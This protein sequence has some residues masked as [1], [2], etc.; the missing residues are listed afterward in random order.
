MRILGISL[1]HSAAAVLIE[2]GKILAA[3]EEEK[4]IRV[5]GFSGFPLA[6]IDYIL[7]KYDLDISDLDEIAIGC[8]DIVEFVYTYRGLNKFFQ[9]NSMLENI[10]GYV[11]Y[12]LK[13]IFPYKYKVESLMKQH[14]F[15]CMRNI[16]FPK[17][18]IKFID[19]HLAHA[20]SSYYTSPWDMNTIVFTNDG[21]G[22]GHSGGVFC[23]EDNQLVSYDY[24]DQKNSVGQL[25][26][27]IT[28]YLGYTVNRHEGKITGL[29]AHGDYKDTYTIFNEI[30]S[31]T[32][33]VLKNKFYENTSFIKDPINFYRKV[34]TKNF[35]VTKYVR[36]L[37][38]KLMN[39]AIVYQL[40]LNYFKSKLS[41]K[42]PQDIAAGVQKFTE[43]ALTAYLLSKIDSQKRYNL[44]LAG[45][46][47]ANV[48]INQ[49]LK[50]IRNIDNV[51][52]HPAMDD[53]GTAL[54]AALLRYAI[55][56]GVSY[57]HTPL[58]TVYLGPS[59]SDEEIELELKKYNIKCK[60][61]IN[62]PTILANMLNAGKIIGRFNGGLEWGPRALGNRSI[63][64]RPADKSINDTLNRRLKRTEFMPFAPSI[65]D[66]DASDFL[67]DYS[68]D[69]IA[70]K[71]MTVTYNVKP[72]MIDKIQATVHVD[73]TARPQVVTKEDNES[74][75]NIIREYKK[76]SGFGVVVN[77]SFNMHEEPIVNTPS[78]AIRAFLSGAV[79]VLSMGP[80]I[81]EK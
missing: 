56:S 36:S 54:G 37:S 22:D 66:E 10:R 47:F 33:G 9:V 32:K 31:Y 48:K 5:K 12:V 25:Y 14:F 75:F 44:C 50:D 71:Y 28:R 61:Q 40:Y 34:K 69:D 6:S 80:F 78:D 45:G 26:Q 58:K 41:N 7:N 49:R 59:Y 62:Y 60:R 18:K 53:S 57:K 20:A 43:D 39:F 65:L 72:E 51:Y 42:R 64:A 2:D 27:S 63:I 76:I 8:S 21:K 52:V 46:V 29:A 3:V 24:I 73:G 15:R 67:E 11:L 74:F 23:N 68:C 77:T 70:A 17:E 13:V 1:G 81:A 35:I 19:H 38:I 4:I 79:D 30:F 16:G 55:N